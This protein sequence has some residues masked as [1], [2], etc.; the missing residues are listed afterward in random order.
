VKASTILRLACGLGALATLDACGKNIGDD[1]A[2]SIDCSSVG[3]RTCDLSQPGGYCT[4]DG[5]DDTSCPSSS[6][7]IRF[8]PQQFVTN[9]VCDP[10][11]EGP[12]SVDPMVAD[13]GLIGRCVTGCTADDYCLPVSTGG[14][15]CSPR[16]DERRLCVKSC[17]GNG[18]CRSG[19]ECRTTENSLM[20][21]G[22]G[23]SDAGGGAV[24][25]L[26]LV[27]SPTVTARFCAPAGT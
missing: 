14:G 2:T 8:F 9:N 15:V 21:G 23:A 19:Y 6:I 27:S 26:P 3:D 25:A 22:T 11:C 7:C 18:D 4:I 10:T 1:C 24:G 16:A 20:T 17:N 5:C 13:A 12:T